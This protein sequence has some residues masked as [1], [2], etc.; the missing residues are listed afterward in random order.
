MPA[1]TALAARAAE[2]P[3]AAPTTETAAAAR[4]PRRS[5][6]APKTSAPSGRIR[7]PTPKVVNDSIRDAN[8]LLLGKNVRPMAAA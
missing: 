2:T 5:I 8:S 7:K 4:R 1:Q 3:A 6:Y